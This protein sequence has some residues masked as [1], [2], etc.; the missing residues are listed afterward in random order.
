VPNP[1]RR[2]SSDQIERFMAEGRKLAKLRHPGIV[3]VHDV[4]TDDEGCF[5]VSDLV[6]GMDLRKC[7]LSGP[8]PVPAALRIV[9]ETAEALHHAH[10]QRIVHRDVKPGN[11]LVDDSG[12]VF[13]TDFGIAATSEEIRQEEGRRCGTPG[14]M[15][16]EQQAGEWSR[17]DQRTDIYSLGVVLYQ[18]LTGVR[19]FE[20]NN[21]SALRDQVL[22]ESPPP[23][24]SLNQEV[25][26]EVERICLKC[27]AKRPEDRYA[28]AQELAGELRC[29]LRE[30]ASEPWVQWVILALAGLLI[31]LATYKVF[32]AGSSS[33]AFSQAAITARDLELEKGMERYWAED[34]PS[35]IIHFDAALAYRKSV[36]V[37]AVTA[38]AHLKLGEYDEAIECCNE[39]FQAQPD[40]A[41]AHYTK[42]LAYEAKNEIERAIESFRMAEKHG[43]RKAAV[44][45]R[46][47]LPEK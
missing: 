45:I 41:K 15:S 3:T 34:Y 27:L 43:M 36:T 18:A 10:Q 9:A 13:V 26:V 17:L 24:R 35:A 30:P 32:L 22:G 20:S 37:L 6:N 47:L 46:R 7:L 28:S 38:D 31:A 29:Q 5:I 8:L 25:P 40:F 16:P 1:N 19:P 2:L 12:R 39:V 11:I 44:E 21:L 4:L 42:G 33:G 14:Y 23:L